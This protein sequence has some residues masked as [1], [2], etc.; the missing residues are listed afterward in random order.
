[1]TDS[2]DKDKEKCTYVLYKDREDWKDVKPIPQDDGP[3]P[4]VVIAYSKKF[5]DAHDYFRAILKSG[6]ISERCLELTKNVILLNP[7]NYTAWR[8]RR[9]LLFH[10]KMELSEEFAF[11][12]EI[13][14][15]FPKNYQVWHHR[16]ALVEFTND[17]SRELA[18]TALLLDC[19]GKNYH[20]WTHRQWVIK[21]FQ[22]FHDE[23]N[24]SSDMIGEDVYNN[25]AWNQ[26]NF[27]IVNT[28]GILIFIL[29]YIF[30][31]KKG[32]TSEVLTE[33]IK[34]TL[35]KIII[36]PANE[37]PW[38]YLR[39]ALMRGKLYHSFPI[40]FETLN[41][42]YNSLTT[43]SAYLLEFL[44]EFYQQ[45]MDPK[46]L[47]FYEKLI[48]FDQI[49]EKYWNYRHDKALNILNGA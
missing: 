6:E 27:V 11:T 1:M 8:Y 20:A 49:R 2:F 19:D 39:G 37:S 45:K 15:S 12:E 30:L 44:A 36:A 28:T 4:V 18:F 35:S 16:H 33:E 40:I 17:A 29:M 31:S 48:K 22:L 43:P 41:D 38:N 21:K 10:L 3:N 13:A 34:Y 26:R 5:V 24:Y 42:L 14:L 7:A 25:S 9:Y 46:C 23:L 47:S 32:Y